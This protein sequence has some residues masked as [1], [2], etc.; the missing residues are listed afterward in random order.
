MK[1]ITFNDSTIIN[2]K[3]IDYI[4]IGFNDDGSRICINLSLHG[5]SKSIQYVQYNTFLLTENDGKQYEARYGV[6]SCDVEQNQHK[7]TRAIKDRLIEYLTND[8]ETP[9]NLEYDIRHIVND[10]RLAMKGMDKEE[11]KND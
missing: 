11:D 7:C 1:L 6:V 4:D 8:S 2:A 5:A 10:I 3:A 9:L